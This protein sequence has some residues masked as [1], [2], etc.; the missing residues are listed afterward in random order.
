MNAWFYFSIIDYFGF[1][2]RIK[3]W[4]QTAKDASKLVLENLDYEPKSITYIG[5]FCHDLDLRHIDSMIS[6]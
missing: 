1:E 4:A 6:F 3:I 5:N 2:K